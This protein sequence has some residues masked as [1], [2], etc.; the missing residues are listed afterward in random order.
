MRFSSL[1][2]LGGLASLTAGQSAFT[3]A[4]P[5]SLP[6]AVKSPYLSTWFPA[7][8]NGGNGGYLPGQWPTFYTG[9][10]TA[11]TGLIR[12]D[13]QTFTWLGAPEVDSD[14][15]NQTAYEYTSSKSIFTI[16]VDDKVTIKASF[17]SP[18]TPKDLKRQSLIA[19]YLNVEVASKDGSDHEVQLYTDIS[20]EWISGNLNAVAHW[21][22]DTTDGLSYHKV[23]KQDQQPFSEVNDRAEWGN[24]YYTTD[25]KHGLTYQSG[26]DKNVRG[27][28][29]SNGKLD[30]TKDTNY[31]AINSEWPV[32]GYA[33]DLGT[34][35]STST[36]VL[37]SIGLYQDE[38]I[39]YLGKNG[40]EILP[41][42]WTSYFSDDVAALSFFHKDFDNSNELTSAFDEQVDKD[43]KA[44][45]G[46]D[47]A[48]L[49]TLAAR[50]VMGA[51]Q[52][53]GNEARQFLFLKEISS[54]G[55]TQT[56]DVIYPATPFFYYANPDLVKLILDPHFENQESGH[57]PYKWA[58]HDLGTHY[59]NATG[60]ADGNDEHMPVEE[61]GN[62]IIMVLKYAQTSQNN[63]YLH[64][65]YPIL[66]QWVE[67]LVED[68]LY[69]SEQLSTDDFA[70]HLANQTNLG[71]K[72]IIG[73]AAFAEIANLI[74]ESADAQNYTSIAKDY[75]TR[76]EALGINA[77]ADPPHATLNYDNDTTYGLLYNLYNDK[78]VG[79]NLVPQRIYDDQSAFYL[80]VANTYGVDL[81]T[82]N[83]FWTKGDWE[84]FCAAVAA[85]ETRDMFISKYA[86]WVSETPSAN[87]FSDLY[88]TDSGEQTGINFRAR[89]VVGGVFA[90]LVL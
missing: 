45:A 69:P 76:W 59:P 44:A 47:Y 23:W 72:G 13:N 65:H 38:A 60:H 37:F 54:N 42:L 20:A 48:I 43:S 19:S 4:R 89:P 80:T 58:I 28:F 51:T 16:D 85:E 7:G 53:V 6:L 78:L 11:W 56:I 18:L 35:G 34:V 62:N 64:E 81:D 70:G 63:D 40:D 29:A 71:L 12:V 2:I 84:I 83:A 22:Y 49:T 21:E 25:T 46:D 88:L 39:Q 79:T 10:V 61:C 67:Y 8:K 75:I 36:S 5:P 33:S 1:N 74:D 87:P 27:A 77:A 31:R 86:K 41:S 68:S 32:F 14:L 52:L 82:R 55:N 9:Q 26:S 66:K 57:Y 15:A 90:L 30:D 73:I 17:I 3:P 24:I 50:Q